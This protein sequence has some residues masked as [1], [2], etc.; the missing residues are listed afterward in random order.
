MVLTFE[1]KKAGSRNGSLSVGEST[2]LVLTAGY[3]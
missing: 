1:G 3:I 2:L